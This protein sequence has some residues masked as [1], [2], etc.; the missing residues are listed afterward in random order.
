MR[1]DLLYDENALLRQLKAGDPAAFTALYRHHSESLYAGILRLVK[2]SQVAEE[3]VQEIFTRI[4]HKRHELTIETSFAAYL[5]KAGQNQVIDFYRKLQRDRRLFNH[6]KAIA[7]EN[8]SHIEEQLTY[9][10]KIVVLQKALD[11][12]PPQQKKVYQL[13][14]M[15][16]FSYK[17]AAS[18]LGI[19]PFTVKEYLTKARHTLKSYFQSHPDALLVLL[20]AAM[21]E[22]H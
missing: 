1:P 17:A 11:T 16:G 3:M 5:H 19:S 9:S 2:I 12:L 6:F 10:E 4:W 14:K 13:C 7:T 20:L 22:A 21:S 8:Y 18:E 15:E